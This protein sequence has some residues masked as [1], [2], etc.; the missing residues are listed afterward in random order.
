VLLARKAPGRRSLRGRS[1]FARS[2][3][4]STRRRAAACPTSI[5]G[6]ASESRSPESRDARR[7][8]ACTFFSL[9]GTFVCHP[10]SPSRFTRYH[11]RE[12][13]SD[14]LFPPRFDACALS[15]H[16]SAQACFASRAAPH[17]RPAPAKLMPT[18]SPAPDSA[19]QRQR[20]RLRHPA[21]FTFSPRGTNPI[22]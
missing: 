2:T 6:L 1:V 7:D 14:A 12:S 21:T 19:A 9:I 17:N 20:Q 4:D 15:P 18:S 22:V 13:R 8:A 10:R 5:R 3:A 11:D 16:E